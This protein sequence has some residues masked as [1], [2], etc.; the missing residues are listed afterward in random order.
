MVEIQAVDDDLDPGNVH[1]VEVDG[2]QT[3]YYEAGTGDPLVL[4]HGGQFGFLSSLDDWS[5]NLPGLS[6]HFHVYSF[7]RLGQGHTGNPRSD[8]DYTFEEVLRHARGLLTALGIRQAHLI[9]HSRGALPAACLALAEPELV[10]S[11]VIVDSSTLAPEN[12]GHPSG[13]FYAEVAR[14]IPAGPPSVETIRVYADALSHSTEHVTADFVRR[15]YEIALL[16][17]TSE[18]TRKMA[19][20]NEEV[21]L[22]SLNRKRDDV[23]RIIEERGF[24]VP[25]LV[26]WGL[27]DPSAP[28]FLGLDLFERISRRTAQA[29]LHVLHRAGHMSYRE[30]PSAFN[31]LIV[32]FCR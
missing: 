18:A 17:K 30:Q 9:G 24:P 11:L 3:R 8:A 31:R 22:P 23:V 21:W 12:S 19:A 1:F 29:E 25:T 2:I 27:N 4:I 15:L 13:A 16:P 26:V 20:L 10:R 6:E 14:R 7:D 32:S 28:L 5:L